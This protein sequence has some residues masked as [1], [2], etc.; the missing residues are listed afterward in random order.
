MEHRSAQCP[1]P[2]RVTSLA[3]RARER[4]ISASTRSAPRRLSATAQQ[5]SQE[6]SPPGRR[7]PCRSN[8]F[9]ERVSPELTTIG[10]AK[11]GPT[12]HPTCPPSTAAA[13]QSIRRARFRV[14]RFGRTHCL[15]R[16]S[17]GS[18]ARSSD[19]ALRHRGRSTNGATKVREPHRPDRTPKRSNK[20]HVPQVISV[21]RYRTQEVAGSSPASSTLETPANRTFDQQALVPAG[22]R[23][24]YLST[25]SAKGLCTPVLYSPTFVGWLRRGGL[26]LFGRACFELEAELDVAKRLVRA[27]RQILIGRP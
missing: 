11:Q 5:R 22:S 18:D 17:I 1:S 10:H 25:N 7:P 12:T 20:R 9:A 8:K 14:I 3:P 13:G 15:R 24:T 19:A 26:R 16:R 4:S 21:R 6:A 23:S 27:S 2:S